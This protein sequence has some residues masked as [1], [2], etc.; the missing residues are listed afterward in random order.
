MNQKRKKDIDAN[1]KLLLKKYSSEEI[2]FLGAILGNVIQEKK[3]MTKEQKNFLIL[4]LNDPKEKFFLGEGTNVLS[5]I[6]SEQEILRYFVVEM[7]RS[8]LEDLESDTTVFTDKDVNYFKDF[9]TLKDLEEYGVNLQNTRIRKLI[10]FIWFDKTI[11]L[12]EVWGEKK[13]A[14]LILKMDEELSKT[15][16][17]S[18]FKGILDSISSDYEGEYLNS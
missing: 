18:N 12:E 7:Q 3:A 2:G 8:I 6:I 16:E 9:F 14:E 5:E 15:M 17:N 10:I 1:V 13:I 11:L 4:M